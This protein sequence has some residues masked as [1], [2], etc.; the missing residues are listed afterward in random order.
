MLTQLGEAELEKHLVAADYSD[1]RNYLERH[2]KLVR[3]LEGPEERS[4]GY[5]DVWQTATETAAEALKGFPVADGN[6]NY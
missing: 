2:A 3:R 1:Y 4:Y 6:D 5:I